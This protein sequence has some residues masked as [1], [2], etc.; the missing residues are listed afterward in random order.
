MPDMKDNGSCFAALQRFK[1][2]IHSRC[3]TGF[4]EQPRPRNAAGD[5]G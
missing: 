3:K 1:N 5:G 4:L 2:L